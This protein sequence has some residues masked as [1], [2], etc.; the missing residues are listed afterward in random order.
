MMTANPQRSKYTIDGMTRSFRL[1]AKQR[2]AANQV[3]T[4]DN[5]G[6]IHSAERIL[7]H[8][9]PLHVYGTY[10]HKQVMKQNPTIWSVKARVAAGRG[11]RTEIEHVAPH[12]ALTVRAIDLVTKHKSDE[13]L[14]RYLKRV[15]QLA[16]LTPDERA[17]LDRQ[18]RS[19]IDPKRLQKAGI[20]LCKA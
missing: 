1:A 2:N 19:T 12:R 7:W 10:N 16:V 3:G 11:K 17:H 5:I 14:M 18:N 6:A 8:L 15:F 13:P 4:S 9:A 20:K